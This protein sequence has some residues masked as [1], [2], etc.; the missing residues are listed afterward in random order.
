VG[1]GIY[2]LFRFNGRTL[3]GSAYGVRLPGR[4]PGGGKWLSGG[5]SARRD[6]ERVRSYKAG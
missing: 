6:V 1:G 3:T 5:G 4:S 2:P